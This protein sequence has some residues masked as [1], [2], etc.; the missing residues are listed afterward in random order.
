MHQ[1]DDNQVPKGGSKA[2]T[3]NIMYIKH[4]SDDGHQLGGT[5]NITKGLVLWSSGL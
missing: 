1:H 5:K 3:R 2:N 4:S